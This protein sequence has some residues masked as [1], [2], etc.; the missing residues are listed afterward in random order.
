M[1]GF[2]SKDFL[3]EFVFSMYTVKSLFIYCLGVFA[4]FFTAFYSFRLIYWVFFSKSNFYKNYFLTLNELNSFMLI[5]MFIL[6]FF[7]IF[8]GYVFYDAFLG[9]GSI[10]WSNAIYVS[11][12]N[13]SILD[14]EFSLL[15]VKFIPLFFTFFGIIIFLIFY[16]YFFYFSFVLI[17]KVRFIYNLYYFFNKAF[18]FDYV[19]NKLFLDFLLK[20]SYMYIYK[21]IEKGFFEYFG[22][23]LLNKIIYIFYDRLSFFNSGLIYYYIFNILVVMIFFIIIFEFMSWLNLVFIFVVVFFLLYYSTFKS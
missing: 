15:F 3:L 5:S 23:I 2:Y 1:T 8:V 10:F 13:Y 14:A 6:V 18:Y 17:F 4:A 9:I 20:Y 12:L 7:S 22:P 21:Y 16:K 11:L 19:L